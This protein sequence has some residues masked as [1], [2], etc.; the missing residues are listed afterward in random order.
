[1]SIVCAHLIL[2]WMFNRSY[3]FKDFYESGQLNLDHLILLK[4]FCWNVSDNVSQK[5]PLL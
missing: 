5:S 4:D 3:T 1:M 2:S